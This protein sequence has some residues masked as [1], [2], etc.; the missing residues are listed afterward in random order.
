MV[1]IP[2]KGTAQLSQD[3]L[4]GQLTLSVESSLTSA[5]PNVPSGKLKAI[6]ITAGTRSALL[7]NVP[8][9]APSRA[10]PVST[11]WL[12]PWPGDRDFKRPLGASGR[13]D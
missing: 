9:V 13:P 3:L 12:A 7:P 11:C 8:T 5:A 1:H 6:A 10:S 2:Y 4:G